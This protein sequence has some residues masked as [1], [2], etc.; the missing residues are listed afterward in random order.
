MPI[1]MDLTIFIL[2][3]GLLKQSLIES[4][5]YY[6]INIKTQT[7]LMTVIIL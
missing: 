3:F 5:T 1:S 7:Y 6:Q 2:I 4:Q